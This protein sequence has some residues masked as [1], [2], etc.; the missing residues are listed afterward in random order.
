MVIS[1]LGQE[2]EKPHIAIYLAETVAAMG[3]KVLLVDANL[4]SPSLHT[5]Y[6]LDNQ[7][8][9]KDLLAESAELDFHDVVQKSYKT[10]LFVLTAGEMASDCSRMLASQ[11]MESLN[12]EFQAAFDLIIYTSPGFLSFMD[13]SFL[14][15]HTDG[16]IGVVKIASTSKSMVLQSLNQM[17][18][19]QLRNLGIIAQS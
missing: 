2:T 7:K 4:R 6:D 14:A 12:Q 5:Q 18:S 1:T 13:T 19:F 16:I 8:G 9:L 3:Q 10:N 17:E 11:Q 15:A